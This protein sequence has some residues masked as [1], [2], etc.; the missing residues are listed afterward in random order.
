MVEIVGKVLD[1]VADA[2]SDGPDDAPVDDPVDMVE[3][4]VGVKREAGR[5]AWV[6]KPTGPV[7]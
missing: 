5:T 2:P 3:I 6:R 4:V 1:D 7:T